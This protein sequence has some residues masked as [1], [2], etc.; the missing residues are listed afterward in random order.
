MFRFFFLGAAR[1]IRTVKIHPSHE[2][3]I[4]DQEGRAP[5]VDL[6]DFNESIPFFLY[7]I[8]FVFYLG[9]IKW[10]LN[11]CKKHKTKQGFIVL[12]VQK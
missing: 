7:F 11:A 8:I 2:R 6:E 10:N 1:L 3:Y 12:F 9:S 4:P 5:V